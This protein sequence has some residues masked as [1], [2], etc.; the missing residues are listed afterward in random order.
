M[1]YSPRL[2][3][4]NIVSQNPKRR[5][6]EAD[7]NT[8]DIIRLALWRNESLPLDG[9]PLQTLAASA[10]VSDHVARRAIKT[11]WDSARAFLSTSL[12]SRRPPTAL[13]SQSK[14]GLGGIFPIETVHHLFVP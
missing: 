11:F 12:L 6:T 9:F 1:D 4:V 10:F 5:L 7:Q 14:H 2:Q 8:M 13:W 3:V